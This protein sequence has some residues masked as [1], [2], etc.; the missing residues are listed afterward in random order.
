MKA[1]DMFDTYKEYYNDKLGF[2]CKMTLKTFITR[3]SDHV[4]FKDRYQKNGLS[5]RSIFVNIKNKEE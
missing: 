5:L 4:D 2:K 1:K 3:C